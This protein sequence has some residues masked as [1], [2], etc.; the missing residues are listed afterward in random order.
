[1]PFSFI[2]QHSNTHAVLD[3]TEI[4][5]PRSPT[6]QSHTY[7]IYN[8]INTANCLLT[9]SPVGNFTFV[10]KRYGGNVSDRFMTEDSGFFFNFV[11]EGDD[12]MADRGFTIAK[13]VFRV[14][15][16]ESLIDKAP[17]FVN[18]A[19]NFSRNA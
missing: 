5:L 15:Y 4:C 1:M 17:I 12:M 6:T 11:E 14:S 3:G 2:N 8:S 19:S 13:I 18:F 9:N 16:Y 7:F 10:L